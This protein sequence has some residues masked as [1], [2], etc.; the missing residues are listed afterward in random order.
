MTHVLVGTGAVF[1]VRHF[2]EHG[3]ELV[4]K[5]LLSRVVREPAARAALARE[6]HVL[7]A[8]RHRAVPELLRL[9]TD[10]HGPFLVETFLR[11]A[12]VRRLVEF[13]SERGGV[14]GRLAAHV[15]RQ[16]FE[17]LAELCAL[18]GPQGPLGFVHGDLGPDHVIVGHTGDVS[19]LDFGASRLTDL[20]AGL[21]GDE[22]GTLPFVAPEIAR[23]EAPLSQAGDVYSMAATALYLSSMEP[24]CAAKDVAAMLLE[25]GTRGLRAELWERAPGFRPTERAVLAAC[26]SVDPAKRPA[27]ASDVLRVLDEA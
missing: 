17:V 3:R 15:T 18:S 4:V 12:S 9:G 22:R 11:G 13:W 2:R 1:E 25:V 8:I 27:T 7:S 23:G 16:A 20:P 21:K 10:E 19:L 26:L 5:R 24:L 14:P 6:A